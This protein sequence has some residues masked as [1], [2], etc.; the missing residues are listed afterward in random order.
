MI[1]DKRK[2]VINIEFSGVL[3]RRDP[4]SERRYNFRTDA[5]ICAA[6]MVML[7]AS[8]REIVLVVALVIVI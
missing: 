7:G 3:R 4:F 2:F 8:L 1:Y 6:A 5:M